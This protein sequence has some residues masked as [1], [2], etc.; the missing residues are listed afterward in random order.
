MVFKL[1]ERL[2]YLRPT[3]VR[4]NLHAPPSSVV[5]QQ[6]G[7]GAPPI[8]YV[9]DRAPF[10]HGDTVRSFHLASR[11]VQLVILQNFC[12]RADYWDGRA[13]LLD[14][15]RPNRITDFNNPGKLRYYLANGET[16]Q[17][18]VMPEAGPGFAPAQQGWRAWS[19]TETLRFTAHDPAWYDPT[20]QNVVF[21]AEATAADQLVFPA[22]FPITF[23]SF[24]G[25]AAIQYEGTWVEYPTLV[26]TGPIQSPLITN[27]ATGDSIQLGYNISTGETVT[28]TLRGVKSI[29]N[30]AGTNLLNYLT[31]DS[32]LTT[33][34]L[35]PDPVATN[36]VNTISVSGSGT[37]N[38]STVTIRYYNRYFGI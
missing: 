30:Q 33:F 12:S 31:S 17:L 19:F 21:T 7:F 4:Y 22:T 28:I 3:G 2:V 27:S 16:R 37:D 11:P 10:Q 15:L 13:R 23:Y 9:T 20:Q 5:L 38:N 18:D 8:E 29:V 1:N 6:E 35:Y 32:D 24:G 26:L 25:S 36:G 34:G 14:T